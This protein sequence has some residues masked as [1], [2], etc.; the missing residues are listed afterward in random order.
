MERMVRVTPIGVKDHCH[1]FEKQGMGPWSDTWGFSW[2]GESDFGPSLV[3]IHLQS[4]NVR[5]LTLA[6]ES[7]P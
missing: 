3:L 7:A 1:G 4:E 6:Q 5:L 2:P